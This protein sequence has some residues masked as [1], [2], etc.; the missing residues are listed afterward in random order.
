MG[1]FDDDKVFVNAQATKLTDNEVTP[2]KNAVISNTVRDAGVSDGILAGML[3]GIGARAHR[4]HKYALDGKWAYGIPTVNIGLVKTH[5]IYDDTPHPGSFYPIVNFRKNGVFLNET[6]DPVHHKET[7]RLLKRVAINLDNIIEN[8]EETTRKNPDGSLVTEPNPIDDLDD[9]FFLFGLDLYSLQ[10]KSAEY[11]YDFWEF[12]SSEV[13]QSKAQHEQALIDFEEGGIGGTL[14]E[15]PSNVIE[16]T[17]GTGEYEVRYIFDWIEHRTEAGTLTNDEG[18]EVDAKSVMDKGG[19]APYTWSPENG[20]DIT[21]YIDT[22]YI[23]YHKQ[24]APGQIGIWKVSGICHET[25][26]NEK[27]KKN[28]VIKCINDIPNKGGGTYDTYYGKVPGDADFGRSSIYL[29]LCKDVLELQHTIQE[30]KV[31]SDA[32]IIAMHAAQEVDLKWYQQ[33]WFKIVMVIIIAVIVWFSMGRLIKEG[34]TLLATITELAIQVGIAF[35]VD[36]IVKEIG[37]ELGM[38]LA[39][40]VAAWAAS[41]GDFTKVQQ[42]MPAAKEVL[43]ATQAVGSVAKANIKHKTTALQNEI[44][45]FTKS[46]K[47]RKEELHE[48][49]L[50]L[51]D[52]TAEIDFLSLYTEKQYAWN[53][54]STPEDWLNTVKGMKNAAPLVKENI[55]MYHSRMKELPRV[56]RD[57]TLALA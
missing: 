20:G 23:E 26:V 21:W 16:F 27:D 10:E 42:I 17:D 13:K 11:G 1:L 24:I 18:K 50:L 14:I 51:G 57:D 29:P 22:G 28:S 46:I 55:S 30:E 53:S 44:A 3:N 52:P 12:T 6:D 45:D 25:I 43:I 38:I 39:V 4:F 49:A 47:E 36:L 48:A 15:I 7:K 56:T 41:R 37:G 19:I 8:I 34:M 5:D 32:M 40:A 33:G 31:L 2:L 54:N 9:C 35:I